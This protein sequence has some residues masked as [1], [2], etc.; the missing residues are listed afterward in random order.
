MANVLKNIKGNATIAGT[1][2]YTV[3]NGSTVTIIGLRAANTDASNERWVT[4]S[5]GGS[6]ISS[7][8]TRL[9]PGSGYEFTDGSKIV[10]TE[11]D[12]IT[13]TSDTDGDIDILI[14][15]LEQS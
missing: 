14:S 4:I 15:M 5:I 11:G 6:Q 10:A 12:I 7:S 9:P 3:P 1:N 13:A 8:Q 2:V